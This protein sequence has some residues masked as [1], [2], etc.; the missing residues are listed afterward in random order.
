MKVKNYF[1]DFLGEIYSEQL[2]LSPLSSLV[3][4]PFVFVK[5]HIYVGITSS[6]FWLATCSARK[7]KV[8]SSNIARKCVNA[9]LRWYRGTSLGLFLPRSKV[10][11]ITQAL[12]FIKLILWKRKEC[13]FHFYI[14]G[15][16]C[17]R[18]HCVT[19]FL[20]IVLLKL[21]F[22]GCFAGQKPQKFR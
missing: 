15:F 19:T 9:V 4:K 11:G 1:R 3:R 13:W 10:L 18:L 14:Y 2:F 17:F 21:C 12:A 6:N 8:S 7:A 5:N 16:S 22:R 20:K